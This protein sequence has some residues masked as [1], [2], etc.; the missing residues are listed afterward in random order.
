MGCLLSFPDFAWTAEGDESSGCKKIVGL[1]VLQEQ[2]NGVTLAFS[3][4]FEV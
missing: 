1:L 2:V 3:N 4:R